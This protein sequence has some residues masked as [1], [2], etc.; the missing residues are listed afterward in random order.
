MIG[1]IQ[2]NLSTSDF[3][4]SGT[5][6]VLLMLEQHVDEPERKRRLV[7]AAL[8]VW[9]YSLSLLVVVGA[10]IVP[11]ASVI[12]QTSPQH[13]AAVR[14]A[15]GLALVGMGLAQLFS[16]PG[17]ILRGLNLDYTSM[18]LRSVVNLV[19]SFA[20]LIAVLGGLGL[21]GLAA[22][23][24]LGALLTGAL[25]MILAR[26]HVEW[27]GVSK[28]RREELRSFFANSM[29]FILVSQGQALLLVSDIVLVGFLF[30]PAAGGV[31][32][33]TGMLI[34][35]G[36][37][38]VNNLVAS[39]AAGLV[40]VCG[41]GDWVRVAGITR[42]IMVLAVVGGCTVGA[43]AVV[44]NNALLG[45]MVGHGFFGNPNLSLLLV[46]LNL[47]QT[48]YRIETMVVDGIRTF[49]ERGLITVASGIGGVGAGWILS[50]FLGESGIALGM[51]LG[52]VGATAALA[53]MV[54][55][56]TGLTI[57]DRYAGG[58]RV[59]VVG[60]VVLTLSY[61][62]RPTAST[63]PVILAWTAAV[64]VAAFIAMA[65]GG[66]T[67]RDRDLVRDKI[68]SALNRGGRATEAKAQAI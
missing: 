24:V 33:A 31:Y 48:F 19:V 55:R 56:K 4:S 53:R 12:I 43:V 41:Q 26:R 51:I 27:F 37:I 40:G 64:G 29:W 47:V 1:Q 30:G 28:P 8:T 59:F 15:L 13:V 45:R 50:R 32:A 36:I 2:S 22:S 39:S 67:V 6:K 17:N 58:G 66:V 9:L 5:L 49:K 16:I 3:R 46:L 38:P 14:L 63:W 44:M 20:G 25:W 60:A 11:L 7:G 21:P 10:I 35:F 34:R 54:R 52:A 61:W 18:G 57:R 65:F 42:Q 68:L 62:L 23:G